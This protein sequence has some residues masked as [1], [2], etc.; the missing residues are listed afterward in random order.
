MTLTPTQL[1][2]M[3]GE[4]RRVEPNAANEAQPR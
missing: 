3:T 4:G 1:R 2:A